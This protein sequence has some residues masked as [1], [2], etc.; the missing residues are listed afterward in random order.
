MRQSCCLASVA[1]LHFS[2]DTHSAHKQTYTHTN[3]IVFTKEENIET[4][5][6]ISAVRP[7]GWLMCVWSI[8]D[9]CVWVC[10]SVFKGV[11]LA[12]ERLSPFIFICWL[13]LATVPAGTATLW[14]PSETQTAN[15]TLKTEPDAALVPYHSLPLPSFIRHFFAPDSVFRSA[16]VLLVPHVQMP[17]SFVT[18]CLGVAV[19]FDKKRN[20][21]QHPSP[22]SLRGL[23]RT[24]AHVLNTNKASVKSAALFSHSTNESLNT[25]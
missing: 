5:A 22:Y 8:S 1:L 25:S 11:V 23:L 18:I 20:K 10:V 21:Q 4:S 12:A 14:F 13:A 9:V 17:P 7:D 6:N 15:L 2:F 3:R 19:T 16:S 24:S